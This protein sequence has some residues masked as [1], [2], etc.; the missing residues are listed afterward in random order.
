MPTAGSSLLLLLLLSPQRVSRALHMQ[1][2]TWCQAPLHMH[3]QTRRLRLCKCK[4]AAA[5]LLPLLL[6]PPQEEPDACTCANAIE[7]TYADPGNQV[8]AS[9]APSMQAS[10][11]VPCRLQLLPS[12]RRVALARATAN[13]LLAGLCQRSH[14]F[15]VRHSQT[16]ISNQPRCNL[17]HSSSCVRV[18]CQRKQ[19][20]QISSGSDNPRTS[21]TP[22]QVAVAAAAAGFFHSCAAQHRSY[23]TS[24]ATLLL[25]LWKIA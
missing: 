24:R 4:L 1:T 23:N 2:Q 15:P 12:P 10:H 7:R 20:V 18:Y 9:C 8:K 3:M 19:Y 25:L 13:Y 5:W 16:N 6:P 17:Q 21:R 22:T 14:L 11:Y